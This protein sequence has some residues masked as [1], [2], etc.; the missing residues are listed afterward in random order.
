M[1]LRLMLDTNMVS[2]VVR[3]RG[4]VIERLSRHP[5]DAICISAITAGE[6]RF[7]L[8]RQPG[9]HRL[10]D[11]MG[12]FMRQIEIMPWDASTSLRYGGLRA[13]MQRSGR[14]MGE[15]DLLIAA[16]ALD[17]DMTLVTNDAG[18]ARVP[19]LAIEDWTRSP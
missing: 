4:I 14:S 8:A 19:D 18:F 7:G 12:L 3:G 13:A 10:R 1:T 11:S 16:H 2:F 5:V 6:I 9:A 15:L 17:L